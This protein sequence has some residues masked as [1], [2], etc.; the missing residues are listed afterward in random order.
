MASV[1]EILFD[2]QPG[3][4]HAVQA[5]AHIAY[6]PRE[7]VRGG[8]APLVSLPGRVACLAGLAAF[9]LGGVKGRPWRR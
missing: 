7:P 5:L 4:R 1:Y 3:L 9:L 2:Y 6:P 8:A